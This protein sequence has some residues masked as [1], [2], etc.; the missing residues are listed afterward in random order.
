M[1]NGI[2]SV[3]QKAP[4]SW[5]MGFVKSRLA[6]PMRRFVNSLFPSESQI[7]QLAA[8]LE[9]HKMRLEWRSSK[10]FVFGTYEREV[11]SAL[12]R[13]VKPGWTVFDI[14]AHIGY[15]TLLLAKLVGPQGKVVAFEP[16]LENFRALGENIRLNNKQN[17][18]IEQCAVAATSGMLSLRSNDTNQ[19]TYTASLVHG[20][21]ICE[22]KVVSLDDYVATQLE[23][24]NFVIMDVEGAETDVLKGMQSILQRDSPTLLIELHGF[25]PSGLLHPALQQLRAMNYSVQFLDTPGAQVHILGEPGAVSAHCTGHID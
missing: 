16:F 17:V 6:P 5:R 1:Q 9:G 19:L 14:G 8:P 24:I 7:F 13:I 20:Q 25:D 23:G 11:I 10:A 18:V 22:V 2:L 3:W 21:P 4:L 15:F 12:Q